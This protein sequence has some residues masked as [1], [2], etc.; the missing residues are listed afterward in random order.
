MTA[1]LCL[2]VN[3]I[4]NDIDGSTALDQADVASGLFVDSPQ[5]HLG[6]SLG[7]R[8]DGA[9]SLFGADAGMGLEPANPK[10][11]VIG[12]G[13]PGEEKAHRVTVQNQA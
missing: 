10:L 5:L 2:K 6:D 4:G 1:Y 7:G 8:L 11:Q 13:G 3:V 9:D 12:R